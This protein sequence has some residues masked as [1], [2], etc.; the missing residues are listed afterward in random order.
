MIDLDLLRAAQRLTDPLCRNN[1][2]D[3]MQQA[4]GHGQIKDSLG[5]PDGLLK[6][7]AAIL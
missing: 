6:E 1:L 4:I 2:A 3:S 5:A 7:W